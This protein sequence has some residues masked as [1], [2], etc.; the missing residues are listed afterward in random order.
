MALLLS[1]FLY[2]PQLLFSFFI[3]LVLKGKFHDWENLAV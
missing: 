1:Y 2:F 3:F